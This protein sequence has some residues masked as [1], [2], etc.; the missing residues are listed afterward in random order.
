MPT[1][2]HHAARRSRIIRHMPFFYGWVILI[3]GT[4]GLV[5]TSPGQTY[6]ISIF[7]EHFID[8]LGL[9]RSYVSTL[10]MIGTVSASF[11][12]PVV[13]RQ[14]DRHGSRAMIVLITVLFGLACL[15]MGLV[16]NAFMLCLGFFALRALGQGSLSLVSRIVVNQWWVRRRGFAIGIV[17]M[18]Y[19]LIG[20]A[21]F[22]VLINAL[23][24]LYGWRGTYS[25]LGLLLLLVMLPLGWLLVRNRPEDYG[26]W[27]DGQPPTASQQDE[28]RSP[29]RAKEP[30]VEE[31]WTLAEVLRLPVFWL[32]SAGFSSISALNTGLTFHIVSIYVDNGLTPTIA[33]SA[34]VP[35]AITSAI[36][37]LGSG[38][39]VDR[40]PS[41]VL[42]AMSLFLHA[43]LLAIAPYLRSIEMALAFGV[44]MG[45][46]SGLQQTIGNSI[47]AMYFGRQHLGSI[48]G[49]TTTISVASSAVGPMLFGIARDVWGS[50][51]FVLL[52]S[53]TLPLALGIA[54]L[55]L[56]QRPRRSRQT[57][58]LAN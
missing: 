31:N 54:I 13:G 40:F 47:W 10:Y 39:L 12:M 29:V 38:M 9:S 33:A 23:I 49:A 19:A 7:I 25:L 48:T 3:A 17:G 15:F 14:I 1:A 45:A 4:L 44:I 5:M 51:T 50:Y 27:P 26:L 16:Q 55:C 32:L 53:A 57:A 41:R 24:P 21:G 35:I 36:V 42:L 56:G 8:D 6:S 46:A 2:D 52:T 22:P 43:L 34:F 37:Q 11:A 28:M 30:W 20:R 18:S 58:T